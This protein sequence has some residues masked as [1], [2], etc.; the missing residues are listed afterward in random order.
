M[1]YPVSLSEYAL[2]YGSAPS[3]AS[4]IR[5]TNVKDCIFNSVFKAKTYKLQQ[6]QSSYFIHI[7]IHMIAVSALHNCVALSYISRLTDCF[8]IV[9]LFFRENKS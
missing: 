1:L 7:H 6:L 9:S 5:L 4:V 3:L 8:F 2:A